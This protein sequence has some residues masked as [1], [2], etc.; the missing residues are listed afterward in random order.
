MVDR[1]L[2]E[3]NHDEV[4][5]QMDAISHLTGV[6]DKRI[7]PALTDLLARTK[8]DQVMETIAEALGKMV[9]PV[10]RRPTSGPE[11]GSRSVSETHTRR[12][13]RQS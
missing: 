1:L 12:R 7:V 11:E 10:L 8:S 5:N 9:I 3:L 6:D 4:A 2:E 13:P